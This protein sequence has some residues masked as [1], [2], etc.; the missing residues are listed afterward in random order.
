MVHL[1]IV[2]S[3]RKWT[4]S[5]HGRRCYDSASSCTHRLDVSPQMADAPWHYQA[6]WTALGVFAYVVTLFLVRRSRQPPVATATCSC[7][8]PWSFSR[9]CHSAPYLGKDLRGP[10]ER[11]KLWIHVGPITFQPVEIAKLMLVILLRFLLRGEAG[12]ALTGGW[13]TAFC[14]T[15]VPSVRSRSPGSSRSSFFSSTTSRCR[16]VHNNV[17]GRHRAVDLCRWTSL[18]S[19]TRPAIR[20]AH[21]RARVRMDQSL[22]SLQLLRISDS[23]RSVGA[24]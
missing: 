12:N 10:A 4:R 23:P 9:C 3:P 22:G 7:S 11:V 5:L 6:A 8:A 15:F 20:E 18:S 21:R 2:S 17:V 14:R 1:A 24:V 13:A 19:G 16:D